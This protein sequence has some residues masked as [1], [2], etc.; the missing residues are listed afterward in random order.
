[1]AAHHLRERCFTPALQVAVRKA[2]PAAFQLEDDMGRIVAFLFGLAAYSAFLGTILYAIGF[3]ANLGVPRSVDVGLEA[4]IGQALVIDTVLIL[5]FAIQHSLMART[6]FKRWLMQFVPAA[7]ERSTYVLLSS[8]A[9]SLLFWQ[10]RSIPSII[11]QVAEPA[12]A[13]MLTAL[14]M[15]G[16]LI[17]LLST[18]LINHF[19][20]FGLYQVASHLTGRPMAEPKFKTPLFYKAVRH[21]LYFGLLVAFWATPVMTVGHLLFSVL[22]T[23]YVVIGALLEERDLVELFGDQYRHYRQKVP[24]LVPFWPK[25]PGAEEA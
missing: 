5:L 8:L 23:A 21:P 1:M 17:V 25:P 9:L 7:I 24:M 6:S 16:W 18:F 2:L 13:L 11:W 14:S 3:I 15:I 12:P 20:L 4:P 22:T 10:W 19:H